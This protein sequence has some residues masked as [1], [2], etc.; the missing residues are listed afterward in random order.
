MTTVIEI[1]Q[2]DQLELVK[3]EPQ[4]VKVP[5]FMLPDSEMWEYGDRFFTFNWD[6]ESHL[7]HDVD[8]DDGTDTKPILIDGVWYWQKV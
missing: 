8:R 3:V 1:E 2:V 6:M 7:F 5:P 4:P